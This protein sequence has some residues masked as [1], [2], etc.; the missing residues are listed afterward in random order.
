MGFFFVRR[1]R[2][3]D[4]LVNNLQKFLF[5]FHFSEQQWQRREELKQLVSDLYRSYPECY[6]DMIGPKASPGSQ[7][8]LIIVF[9]LNYCFLF[10]TV[11]F[12]AVGSSSSLPNTMDLWTR[13]YCQLQSKGLRNCIT[14][15]RQSGSL[16]A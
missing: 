3:W 9:K 4:S 14:R 15:M 6:P 10:F 2:R 1:R 16:L 13:F 5:V 12:R 8:E 11:V 7:F